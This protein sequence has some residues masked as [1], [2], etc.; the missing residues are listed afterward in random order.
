MTTYS[1]LSGTHDHGQ[2]LTF[3]VRAVNAL[4]IEDRNTE[5]VTVVAAADPPPAVSFTVEGK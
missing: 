2:V 3:G 4:G 5:Y 1:W